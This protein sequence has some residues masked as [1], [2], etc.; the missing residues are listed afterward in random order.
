MALINQPTIGTKIVDFKNDKS[1]DVACVGNALM[2]IL[3]EVEEEFLATHDLTKGGMELVGSEQCE[4]QLAAVSG[5]HIT[6]MPGGASANTARGVAALGGSA[7]FFGSIGTSIY[8][9]MYKDALIST[10]V[11][12]YLHQSE[13][14]TGNA[15]TY[16]TP[17]HERT[18]SVHLGAAAQLVES[19][20]DKKIIADSKVVHLEAFQLEGG[21]REVL[22]KVL[23]DAKT[24]GT[25]VSLDLN[26]VG[27]IQRNLEF[28]KEVVRESVDIL[29]ANETE[30]AT[31]AGKSDI[32]DVIEEIKDV[33]Q[34]V[35]LKC[36][37]DGAYIMHDG[38]I[39]TIAAAPA[40][41]VDTTGAGD[42][43]AAGFLYGLTHGYSFEQAGE[44]GAKTAAK[45]IAQI[46]VNT[47]F[48]E[49]KTSR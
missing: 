41:V 6:T 12:P 15:I 22:Q 20:I 10:G 43:F 4:Q 9:G 48:I 45:I 8:G 13:L 11:K 2:D 35:V 21:T 38:N 46:G 7:V 24:A 29:F 33:A 31:F 19:T 28:F 17:D 34:I 5:R 30:G 37:A 40:N 39:M 32:L 1:I 3:L 23:V 47:D 36:G 44:L 42:L 14:L 16:I 25:L 26:D 18:F 27:L 49:K